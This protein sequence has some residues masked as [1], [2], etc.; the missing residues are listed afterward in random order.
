MEN[1]ENFSYRLR[2]LEAYENIRAVF[3]DYSLSADQGRWSDV[4][5]LFCINGA[6]IVSGYGK[7]GGVDYDGV[8]STR[9]G[10]LQY[11]DTVMPDELP[12]SKHNIIPKNISLGTGSQNWTAY[13]VSY[14]IGADNHAGGI[15]EAFLREVDAGSW[16]FLKLSCVNTAKRNISD[17]IVGEAEFC[18]LKD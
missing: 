12:K 15:Y 9:V 16:Q 2:K 6:L 4:A 18:I 11:Y 13:V 17:V 3:A 7:Y 8:F 14:L 10:I 1:Q 5:S